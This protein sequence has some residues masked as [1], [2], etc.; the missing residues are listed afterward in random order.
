M[1]KAK[2]K[3][4]EAMDEPQASIRPF[5]KELGFRTRARSFNRTTSDAITHVIEFQVAR[6]DPPGTQ[7]YDEIRQNLYGSF[8]VNI[9]V[10]VPELH[11]YAWKFARELTFVREYDCWVRER[12]GHLGPERQDIWWKLEAIP[13]QAADVFERIERDAL[14]FLSKF[15]TREAILKQWMQESSSPTDSDFAKFTRSREM[16]ACGIILAAQGRRD[17]AKSCL[18]ASLTYKPGHR[19]SAGI[20]GL[21]E[22]L[23]SGD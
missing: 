13:Q 21:L 1:A 2:S 11:D 6:F 4:V 8:T 19:P 7:Y 16:L 22:K 14:P 18:R 15:E 23:E 17:E 5:L 12:L 20:Q 9:G 3:V 10:F